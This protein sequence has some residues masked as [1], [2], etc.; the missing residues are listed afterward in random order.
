M[1]E[2]ERERKYVYERETVLFTPTFITVATPAVYV[3]IR[4]ADDVGN[5]DLGSFLI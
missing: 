5:D 1:E 3:N 4:V 2:D